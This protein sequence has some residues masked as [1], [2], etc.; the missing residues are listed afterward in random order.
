MKVTFVNN[1]QY[2]SSAIYPPSHSISGLAC[3]AHL[4]KLQ[5]HTTPSFPQVDERELQQ[6]SALQKVAKQMGLESHMM[7][8]AKDHLEELGIG[9]WEL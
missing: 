9:N 6:A 5:G 7:L 4:V 8:I 1:Q 2:S 3:I